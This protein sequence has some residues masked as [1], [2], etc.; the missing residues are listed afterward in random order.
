MEQERRDTAGEGVTETR[1]PEMMLMLV[2]FIW[3]ATFFAMQLM[4]RETGPFAVI[5]I[6]F[7]LGSLALLAVFRTRM[8]GLTR[9]EI[10]AGVG[11]G[12]VT[13]GL[14]AL[15]VS[16]LQHIASSRSAFITA[17][18]V[19]MVPL[20]Q[21]VLLRQ[22]PALAA[23]AGIGVSFA[24]LVLLS[25]GGGSDLGL[26][27]GEW[28]TLGCAVMAALQIVLL[29]RWAA[30]TDALRLAFVQLATVAVL[31]LVAMPLAGEGVGGLSAMGWAAGVALGLLGTAFALGAMSWAQGTVSPTRA[32]VIYSMEPVWGGVVGAMAGE[33]LTRSTLG[34]S[35]LI[36]LGVLVSELRW[37][38]RG[39]A[40]PTTTYAAQE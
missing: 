37:R 16:G 39:A 28:L 13:F 17:L 15:Q 10:R 7:V 38:P 27:L 18:Y 22:A 26:G 20:L 29:G 2:T 34:G 8:R 12:V 24:G 1:L 9:E 19:P 5:A 30:R 3:G 36:V 32:T 4:L 11:I 35:L 25:G 6:R 23:W 21:L 33:V 40:L 14:Y 31:A